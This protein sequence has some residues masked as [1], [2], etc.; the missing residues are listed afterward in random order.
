MNKLKAV[1]EAMTRPQTA[2]ALAIKELEDAKRAY[3][4][5]K[6]HSEYYSSQCSFEAQRIARLEKYLEDPIKAE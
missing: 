2:K 1:W 3:L 5:A 4:V 6:T